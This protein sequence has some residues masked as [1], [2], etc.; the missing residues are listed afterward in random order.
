M[1]KYIAT[2]DISKKYKKG[3]VVSEEDANLY[4]N[5][6]KNA[7]ISVDDKFPTK[8]EKVE[9]S[10]KEESTEKKVQ[11]EKPVKNKSSKKSK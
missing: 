1:V 4:L 8:E 9:E 6:Y 10:V 3:D 2:E 7:P 11:E 5:M